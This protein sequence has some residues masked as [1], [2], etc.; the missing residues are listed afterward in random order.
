MTRSSRSKCP[1]LTDDE[2]QLEEISLGKG[3]CLHAPHRSND[4]IPVDWSYNCYRI[5]QAHPARSVPMKVKFSNR[6]EAHSSWISSR[7]SSDGEIFTAPAEE[8]S[9]WAALRRR[10][11]NTWSEIGKHSSVMN[12]GQN[13]HLIAHRKQESELLQ[14]QEQVRAMLNE[15][16]SMQ[17]LD[18][19]EEVLPGTRMTCCRKSLSPGETRW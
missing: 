8:I 17:K 10:E 5:A 19:A 7:T 6:Y 3:W 1:L 14:R 2:L 15:R 16:I 13:D 18:A 9:D 4:T 11:K 12:R